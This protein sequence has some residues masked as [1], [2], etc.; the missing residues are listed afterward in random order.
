MAKTTDYMKKKKAPGL[1]SA[2]A[3]RGGL[4]P[5]SAQ[6]RAANAAG[7]LIAKDPAAVDK[8]IRGLKGKP[9]G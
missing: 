5:P 7:R 3:V 8:W 9:R 1:A 4:K 2:S 6:Q